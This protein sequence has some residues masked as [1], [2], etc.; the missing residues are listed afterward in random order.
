M[1]THFLVE[2]LACDI[3][4]NCP[5]FL[6]ACRRL[7]RERP[8][9]R[10]AGL[11][12]H[13]SL[14]IVAHSRV[15]NKG[16]V[17]DSVPEQTATVLTRPTERC[18][19]DRHTHATGVA[20]CITCIPYAFLLSDSRD[21]GCC[22]CPSGGRMFTLLSH[23]DAHYRP[24]DGLPWPLTAPRQKGSLGIPMHSLLDGPADSHVADGDVSIPRL[25]EDV[26]PPPSFHVCDSPLRTCCGH[27]V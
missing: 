26:L 15:L 4:L 6:S 21:L 3:T 16:A 18:E 5:G 1:K 24:S 9:D 20:I 22:T 14:A 2:P 25:P 10:R 7:H 13:S 12:F 27:G 17:N 8:S 19:R 23:R 11:R